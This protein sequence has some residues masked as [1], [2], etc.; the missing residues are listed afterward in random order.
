MSVW[1]F[2]W[3]FL[4]GLGRFPSVLRLEN[5]ATVPWPFTFLKISYL[6]KDQSTSKYTFLTHF[7]WRT[8]FWEFILFFSFFFLLFV[9]KYS[10]YTLNESINESTFFFFNRH[11]FV[12]TEEPFVTAYIMMHVKFWESATPRSSMYWMWIVGVMWLCLLILPA[13]NWPRLFSCL[14][15]RMLKSRKTF[16]LI[17][18]TRRSGTR[19]NCTTQPHE[20]TSKWHWWASPL[21]SGCLAPDRSAVHHYSSLTTS[22]TIPWPLFL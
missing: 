3:W 13:F 9:D 8:L 1:I 14:S 22:Q 18:A 10:L 19:S 16:A 11:P 2:L 12:R 15:F 17:S 5:R 21:S 4:T 20:T 7:F 6:N